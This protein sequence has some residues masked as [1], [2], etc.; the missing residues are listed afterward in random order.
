MKK[1]EPVMIEGMIKGGSYSIAI[2]FGDLLFV[3]GQGAFTGSS[4][5]M[6]DNIDEQTHQTLLNIEK[7]VIGAGSSVKK[8][9][10]TTVFLKNIEDFE[11]MNKVYAEFFSQRRVTNDYPARTTVSA[12]LPLEPMLIEIE[13]IVAL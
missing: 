5:P 7:V 1:K 11:K 6:A 4:K 10:K 8:I 12:R 9:L 2:K 3:S 13:A